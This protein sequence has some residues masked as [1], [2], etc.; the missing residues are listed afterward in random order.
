M[1]CMPNPPYFSVC[2]P[3]YNR[4]DFLIEALRGFA[5][6]DFIDFEICISDGGSTDG[7]LPRIEAFLTASGLRHVIE[8]SD[9]N[10]QYD[11][12]LRRAISM[13]S[14]RYL[15]LM[16]NDDALVDGNTLGALHNIIEANA[17]VA[18]AITNY[19]E[20]PH[21][22]LYKRMTTTGIIGQGMQ[23]AA[24]TFRHYSFVSGLILAGEGSRAAATDACDG[25]EMYQMYLGSRLVGQGGNFLAI[26]RL[27]INKD[28]QI[29]G[30]TVESYRTRERIWPC[31]I[32]DRPLPLGRILETVALGLRST[33]HNS[34]C[35]RAIASVARQ[36]YLFTYP[37]WIFEYRRVQSFNYS[38][39]V[40]MALRP[41]LTTRKA[42]LRH[43]DYLLVWLIYLAVGIVG[44]AT[45][46]SLFDR[47][48]W[49]LYRLAKWTTSVKPAST[50]NKQ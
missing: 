8:R 36:L 42:R 13:S 11:A 35:D 22:R 33:T 32:Q 43:L 28:I 34:E 26:D 6:Q 48:R 19:R 31:P 5:A 1:I 39:G 25:G 7:G 24:Q 17:P 27:C 44:F 41:N 16:G 23:T 47:L 45:P 14:G 37:F 50:P 3:Q 12:N 10:L 15:L 40:Y 9:R 4:T 20:L 18:V 46:V 49:R 30:Q 29:P 2:I 38:L 21:G